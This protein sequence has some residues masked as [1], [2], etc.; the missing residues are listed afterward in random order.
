MNAP[1]HLLHLFPSSAGRK[2]HN[3]PSRALSRHLLCTT[4]ASRQLARPTSRPAIASTSV[5]ALMSPRLQTSSDYPVIMLSALQA[6]DSE[7]SDSWI[8]RSLINHVSRDSNGNTLAGVFTTSSSSP[9][10]DD[11][12]AP[13]AIA[14]PVPSYSWL[15]SS[16]A[17][18]SQC[19]MTPP[20]I[21][22]M[23]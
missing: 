18:S 6:H 17:P 20:P 8:N 1:P 23:S 11:I 14:S 16:V 21:A 4:M 9:I 15:A 22:T 2:S 7:H 5:K 13:D 10:P 12:A 19:P 3:L